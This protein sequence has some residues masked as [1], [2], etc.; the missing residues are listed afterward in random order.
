[1]FFGRRQEI[2][3]ISDYLRNGDSV[4]LIG[5]RRIGKTFLLYMIGDLAR[6]MSGLY[7]QL[8]DQ[9]TGALLV[10]LRNS[11]VSYRWPYVDMLT[12]TSVSG[13]Y[14]KVLAEL[15]EEQ[16]ERFRLLLPIDHAVF[17]KE[18]TRISEQL[19][20]KGQRAVVSVDE[21]EKLLELDGSANVC[22]C[23]KAAIQQ[24]QAV[25]FILA[26]DIKPHQET[27]EF[28][29]LRGAFRSVHL[30]PLDLADAQALVQAPVEG[31][32]S[33][34]EPALQRIQELTGG[35]PSLIQ[36]LCDHLYK[37]VA[38]EGTGGTHITLVEFDGLW[39][40][41]LREHVF[42]SFDAALRDFFEGLQGDERSIFC[43]LAHHP[44]TTVDNIA[45][46]LGI[47]TP[48]VRMALYQLCQTHRVAEEGAGF[49]ISAKIVEEYG[50]RFFTYPVAALIQP[51]PTTVVSADQPEMVRRTNLRHHAEGIATLVRQWHGVKTQEEIESW[52]LMF[53]D[54]ERDVAI[55]LL[56]NTKYYSQTDINRLYGILHRKFIRAVGQQSLKHIWF[57]GIGGAAKSGQMTL[58]YYK[59]VNGLS[60]SHFQDLRVLS[61]S[62][63]KGIQTLAFVDDFIGTGNQ[64][65]TFWDEELRDQ[66][67]IEKAKLYCLVLLAFQSAIEHIQ[68]RTPFT[69]ICAELLDERDRVF[70]PQCTIFSD[71]EERRRAERICR[72][73]GEVLCPEFP[74]GYDDS[75]ALVA[76]EYQTPNNSLPILWSDKKGWIPIFRRK[77]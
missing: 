7:E 9:K 49:R 76:F 77:S 68:A 30:G 60:E 65:I 10:E 33:F 61:A 51:T 63:T 43:F 3:T 35:K 16:A 54:D 28:V 39:E 41:A 36:I 62:A 38:P 17:L 46:V 57:F 37:R 25:D 18:L 48:R 55:K 6:G 31:Q 12:V 52:L 42:Q 50:A 29:S 67:G 5:E 32:L 74:L 24:C 20:R 19:S 8:L 11:T 66:H 64:V 21:S 72:R 15:A 13:F 58:Y 14:F 71:E 26:G 69:V 4:L 27:P 2:Q 40:S 22:S 75:Q 1:M 44:L 23:L 73:Y 59:A 56:S 53:E 47:Q 45:E 70:S 34:D